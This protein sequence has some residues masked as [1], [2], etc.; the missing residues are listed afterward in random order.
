VPGAVEAGDQ[1]ALRAVPP[2]Q[3]AIQTVPEPR[4]AVPF[5]PPAGSAGPDGRRFFRIDPSSLPS[6]PPQPRAMAMPFG[7]QMSFGTVVLKG[8]GTA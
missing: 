7:A 5:V 4:P 3:V 8:R 2:A 6:R 1:G